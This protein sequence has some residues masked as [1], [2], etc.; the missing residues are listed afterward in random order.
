MNGIELSNF[1]RTTFPA[2]PDYID[3]RRPLCGVGINDAD[4]ITQPRINGKQV[5]C[6][7]YKLW[8]SMID[9]GYSDRWKKKKPTY[10]DV[11]VC[12]EWL[13][14]TKFR[15]WYCDNYIEGWQLD[16][17]LTTSSRQYGPHACVFVPMWMNMFLH[18]VRAE[19]T[20][21]LTGASWRQD[22]KVYQ[23]RCD[24]I[25]TGEREFLGVFAN[26][27][28][29]NRAWVTRKMCLAFEL[30]DLMDAIDRRIYF[31]VTDI[32]MSAS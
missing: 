23:S 29:A 26:E 28:E 12:N 24:N 3:R 9:R 7:A 18:G 13:S 5:K 20:G 21:G 11:T 1:I 16:K 27:R 17:D 15:E 30:K 8:A 22:R 25:I 19:A 6:P 32:I 31:R 4:Y 2:N 10:M 14:F